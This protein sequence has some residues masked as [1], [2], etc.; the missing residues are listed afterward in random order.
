[1][2]LLP[3]ALLAGVLLLQPLVQG[4]EILRQGSGIHLSLP[5]Q[6]LEG[7]RPRLARPHLE[8]RLQLLSCFLAAVNG[9]LMQWTAMSGRFAEG[10]MKLELKDPRQEVPGVRDVGGDVVFRSRVEVLFGPWDRRAHPLVFF[11]KVPPGRIV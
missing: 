7:I 4:S 2:I 1:M 3:T 6:D 11:S 10:A 5:G 8:H 9:A